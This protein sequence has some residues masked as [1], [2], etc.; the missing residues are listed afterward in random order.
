MSSPR[1]DLPFCKRMSVFRGDA[2]ICRR[3]L[4]GIRVKGLCWREGEE[5]EE[6]GQDEEEKEERG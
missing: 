3:A 6:E 5:R 4:V 1:H 2:D